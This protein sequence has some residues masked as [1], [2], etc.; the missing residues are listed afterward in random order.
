VPRHFLRAGHDL[1]GGP[2]RLIGFSDGV[3]AVAITLVALQ[4]EITRDFDVTAFIAEFNEELWKLPAY[5][6]T[7]LIVGLFWQIHHRMFELIPRQNSTLV[8]LNMTFLASVCLVPFVSSTFGEYI[9]S[10]DPIARRVEVVYSLTM[11]ACGLLLASCWWYA[12]SAHRRLIDDKVGPAMVTY[13]RYRGLVTPIVFLATVPV[14]IWNPT[15]GAWTWLL[16]IPAMVVVNQVWGPAAD[17]E[18]DAQRR[19]ARGS[20]DAPPTM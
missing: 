14:G 6:L 12:S 13:I 20:G 7:F 18:L 10:A 1:Y 15:L 2:D 3:F 16:L 9:N 5:G 4:F 17:A 8:V 19:D 11:A